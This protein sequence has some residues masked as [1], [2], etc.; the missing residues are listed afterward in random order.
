MKTTQRSLPIAFLTK[1]VGP[2]SEEIGPNNF[3]RLH[4]CSLVL[5]VWL[6]GRKWRSAEVQL[7]PEVLPQPSQT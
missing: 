7:Q 1:S 5:A 2:T 3:L 4:R 6:S